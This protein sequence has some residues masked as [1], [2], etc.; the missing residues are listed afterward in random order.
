MSRNKSPSRTLSNRSVEGSPSARVTCNNSPTSAFRRSAS[1]WMRSSAL[2]S[3]PERANSTATPSRASGDRNSC[4]ISSS[5]LRSAASSVWM[6]S[7]M[8]LKAPANSPSSSRRRKSTR[9]DRSPCPKRSTAFCSR[10]TGE[11]RCIASQ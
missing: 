5:S 1:F 11:V 8:R 9:A 6:R 4:E 3:P 7:A 10:R 2:P